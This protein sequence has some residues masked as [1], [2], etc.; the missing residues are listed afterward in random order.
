MSAMVEVKESELISAHPDGEL[1]INIIQLS[2]K[3]TTTAVSGVE[4]VEHGGYW[5]AATN[6]RQV[7]PSAVA[8]PP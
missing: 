8:T 4:V 3:R 7:Q 1:K 5:T 2:L 6:G